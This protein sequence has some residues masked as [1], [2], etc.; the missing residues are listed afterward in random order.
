MPQ[1][2]IELPEQKP[3]K[4]VFA[5]LNEPVAEILPDPHAAYVDAESIRHDLEGGEF[6]YEIKLDNA[7]A[8]IKFCVEECTI[9]LGDKSGVD[10]MLR[11]VHANTDL[12]RFKM[13]E[14]TANLK[15]NLPGEL[16]KYLPGVG[17]DDG[18][19]YQSCNYEKPNMGK[20]GLYLFR[21]HNSSDVQSNPKLSQVF[22]LPIKYIS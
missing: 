7:P 18:V 14:N 10:W 3:Y 8:R 17:D 4:P 16:Q 1:D 15:I 19:V 2:P 13:V 6:V 20:Y 5:P 12:P 22:V 11:D 21:I 9:V